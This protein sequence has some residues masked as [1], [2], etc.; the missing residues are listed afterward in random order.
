MNTGGWNDRWTGLVQELF[1]V[2]VPASATEQMRSFIH[3]LA[4]WNTIH[5]LV[6]YRSEDEL[7]LRH[8]VDSLAVLP[9]LR[10]VRDRMGRDIKIADIGAGAGF[11]GIPVAIC[12][13][14]VQVTLIESVAKKGVFMN[15][16]IQKLGLGNAVVVTERAE[17]LGR[18]PAHRE[19]YDV[20]LSR[21]AGEGPVILELAMPLVIVGGEFLPH[22][23]E[24][25]LA[26]AD[27][28]SIAHL[29]GGKFQ[30]AVPYQLPDNPHRYAIGIF[31]KIASISERYP[32][33][34][35]I[36]EKRPLKATIS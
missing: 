16:V 13:P 8:V 29:L 34:T 33:R 15:A 9:L 26:A 28:G 36:P 27:L 19:Q 5:N 3:E 12:M 21:A 30:G 11:P 4:T 1:A 31:E 23:T 25:S 6:S 7:W 2:E 32:R 14:G 35:G 22:K 24:E 18:A 10:R 17:V 20:V